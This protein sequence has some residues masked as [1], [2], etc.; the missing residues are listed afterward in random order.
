MVPGSAGSAKPLQWVGSSK[1]DLRAFPKD[2]RRV[3]GQAMFEAQR[4]TKHLDAKPMKG[5]GGAG[6]LEVVKRA[7]GN[8]YRAVYTIRFYWRH[9]R[10]ARLSEEVEAWHRDAQARHRSDQIPLEDCAGALRTSDGTE[11]MSEDIA[12][13]PSSGNVFADLGLDQPEEELV[14]AELTLRIRQIIERRKLT[15]E[16]A[17]QILGVSEP[18]V[19][20]LVRGDLQ[21]LSTDRLLTC[22]TALDRDVQILIKPKPRSQ[23]HGRIS[24]V[25]T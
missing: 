18:Q 16:K 2:V 15:T 11:A 17:A 21:G 1:E 14:K 24:V 7:D 6:V 5:F 8:T 12:V 19:T 3:M 9:L 22:L 20:Q 4:G 25:A 23:K 10:A 13:T